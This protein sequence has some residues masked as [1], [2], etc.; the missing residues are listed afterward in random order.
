LA[1]GVTGRSDG[2]CCLFGALLVFWRAGAMR[3]RHALLFA[4]ALAFAAA[5]GT[6]LAHTRQFN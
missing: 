3:I 1:S 6:L 5:S 2:S 4:A